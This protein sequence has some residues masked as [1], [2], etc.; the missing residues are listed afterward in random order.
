[1]NR[2]IVAALLLVLML[3]ACP[4]LGENGQQKVFR[5]ADAVPFAEGEETLDLYV[6]PLLGADCMVIC[7]QGQTMMVDMGKARDYDTIMTVLND[8][9]ITHI[10][11]AFNTHPHDDHL[12]SMRKLLESV[13]VG[14]FITVFPENYSS[15]DTVQIATLRA[16]REAGVPV[17]T[18]A[19][20]DVIT[21]GDMTATVYRQTK[22][23][24]TNPLSAMLMVC[25]GDSRLLL[26]A[27]V[28]GS[29]QQLFADTH[30]LKAD[31]FK[32]PHH[33]LNKVAAEFLSAIDPEYCFFTHG[34]ANTKDSQAQMDK[35]GVDYDFATWGVIHLST[36]GEYWIVDQ[37]LTEDGLRYTEKYR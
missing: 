23:N 16:A 29:A 33:G 14:R 24:A 32:F 19:D 17:E 13:T 30:D 15:R 26:T 35:Y 8:L 28:I 4:A 12:G 34:Y 36:N 18:L 20:G 2:R 1:M 22:Y 3:F 37:A 31:I 27:D 5:A 11:V 21:L 9:G 6:A 25:Y 10:D 7:V